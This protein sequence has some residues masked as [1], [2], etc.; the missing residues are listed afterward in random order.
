MDTFEKFV[1][2]VLDGKVKPYLKSEPIPESNDAP[3][4]V[5]TSSLISHMLHHAVVCYQKVTIIM[6]VEVRI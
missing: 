3:V 2:D 5:C 1:N 4:K 6:E